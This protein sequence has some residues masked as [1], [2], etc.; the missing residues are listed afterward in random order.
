MLPNFLIIGAQKAGTSF[1]HKCMREHPDVFSPVNEIR[2]FE[3]PEYQQTDIKQFEALF[4]QVSHETAVGIKRPDYL[5]KAECPARIHHHLPQVKL[6]LILRNPIERAVSA[7]F[8]QMKLGFIP[9]RSAEE[10]LS[11]IVEG[12]YRELYPKSNEIIDYGFYYRHLIRYL[13]Y[14]DWKQICIILF[15]SLRNDPLPALKRVYNFI[16]VDDQYVPKTLTLK[17]EH[18]SGIYSL[19]RLK[20][21]TLR[22][23]FIYTYNKSRTKV[24]QKHSHSWRGTIS[25]TITLADDL[26]LEPF[27]GNPKP[28]LSFELKQRLYSLY[29]DDITKLELLLGQSLDRWRLHAPSSARYELPLQVS[30]EYR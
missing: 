5:A 20:W 1:I 17:G 26:F 22:N 2:F 30:T 8:H 24:A 18:N 28:R 23:P 7:Y 6:I 21:L 12:K 4:D 15:N 11:K 27:F 25:K 14:F 19:T 3:D 13:D 9:I 29:E 16:G 10:G